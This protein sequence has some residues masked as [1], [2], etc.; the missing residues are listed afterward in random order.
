MIPTEQTR[1]KGH[2]TDLERAA[3]RMSVGALPTLEERVIREHYWHR[4]SLAEIAFRLKRRV[5]EVRRILREALESVRLTL[6][7]LFGFCF[8]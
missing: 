1:R 3:V 8:D 5:A 7:E 2:L 4:Q 6:V